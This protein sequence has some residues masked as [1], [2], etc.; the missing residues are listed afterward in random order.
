MGMIGC[1]PVEMWRWRGRKVGAGRHGE[2]VNDDIK[3][4]G[5]LPVWALLRDMC[6]GF[7]SVDGREI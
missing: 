7:I 6:R 2:C 3:V 4:P 1:R 5:L